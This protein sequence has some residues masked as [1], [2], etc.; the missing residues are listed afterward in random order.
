MPAIQDSA[1]PHLPLVSKH[2]SLTCC[3][4]FQARALSTIPLF[5]SL[6]TVWSFEPA[7]IAKSHPV[8]AP[9]TLLTIDL[10]YAFASPLHAQI[11]RAFFGKVSGLMVEAF[12]KRCIEIYGKV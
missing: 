11:S 7:R 3:P 8:A 2:T 5:K 6:N 4:T 1:G 10:R 12:E 9:Q